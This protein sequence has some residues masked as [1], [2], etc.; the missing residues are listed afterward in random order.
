MTSYPALNCNEVAGRVTTG[1]VLTIIFC[2]GIPVL[3]LILAIQHHR[4]K[5]CSPFSV[6][7]VKTIFSGHKTTLRGMLYKIWTLLRALS[8]VCIS[9][10]T[11][12]DQQQAF[13]LVLLL[14]ATMLLESIMEPRLTPTMSLLDRFQQLAVFII[15][16]LGMLYSGAIGMARHR[17]G[18]R[19]A[20]ASSM[21]R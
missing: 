1:T 12:S 4:E 17:S 10:S 14:T 8:F 11:L 21:V 19:R 15:I 13:S 5:I 20:L 16:C 9:Q 18:G 3:M 2:A 7:L 6:Y